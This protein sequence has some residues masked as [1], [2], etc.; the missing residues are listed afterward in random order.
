M[1]GVGGEGSKMS[2]SHFPQGSFFSSCRDLGLI[3]F[4]TRVR[5][6]G[7]KLVMAFSRHN[8]VR[9]CFSGFQNVIGKGFIKRPHKGSPG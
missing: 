7:Q 9:R 1:R 4:L 8:Y 5:N 6:W 2:T 3:N